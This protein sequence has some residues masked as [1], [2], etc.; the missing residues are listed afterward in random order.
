MTIPMKDD[1]PLI[2]GW[3]PKKPMNS[4]DGGDLVD[5]LAKVQLK[6]E[7]VGPF[8]EEVKHEEKVETPLKEE[9]APGNG[10]GESAIKE[11][12]CDTHSEGLDDQKVTV[13]ATQEQVGFANFKHTVAELSNVRVVNLT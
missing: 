5:E 10:G 7:D 3:R 13:E 8:K 4:G 11:E 9:G 6:P 12:K 1:Q 2:K